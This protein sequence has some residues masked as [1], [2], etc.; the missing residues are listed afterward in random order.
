M[1][2]AFFRRILGALSVEQE[3]KAYET[4]IVQDLI[5]TPIQDVVN[6]WCSASKAYTDL[7]SSLSQGKTDY[8]LDYLR[9]MIEFHR[10]KGQQY[11]KI[12]KETP[13]FSDERTKDATSSMEQKIREMEEALQN[14]PAK[15]KTLAS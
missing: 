5:K 8:A 12:L 7:Y 11:I 13:L 9:Q 14:Y 2:M 6:G 1:K 3:A 4:K 15:S 10:G